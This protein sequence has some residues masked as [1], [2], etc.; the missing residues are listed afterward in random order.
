MEN[1]TF[2]VDP[3]CEKDFWMDDTKHTT[4]VITNPVCAGTGIFIML[5]AVFTSNIIPKDSQSTQSITLFC[6]CRASL[7]IVGAG[8]A[9]FHSID[10]LSYVKA[11]NFRMCDRMPIILMCTN[12]FVLYFTKLFRDLT[13]RTLTVCFTLVYAYMCG[14]ILATDS[15]TYA[16]LTLKLDDPQNS[17]QSRYEILLNI[18][19]LLPIGLILAYASFTKMSGS[20]SINI[21]SQIALSLT[22]WMIN[23]YNCRKYPWLFVFH[24][25]FHVTIAYTFLYASCLGM[26]LDNEWRLVTS[27]WWPMIQEVDGDGD[28]SLDED[29][30]YSKPGV[31]PCDIKMVF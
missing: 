13:E 20:D 26:T 24:A 17:A 22:I 14:L 4:P 25:I 12:I 2:V 6:M 18:P 28:S 21:W 29:C 11:F 27:N 10:D 3:F 15:T 19:V 5:M 1:F 8:T 31:D 7:A 23:A 9:V 16:Y 30:Y